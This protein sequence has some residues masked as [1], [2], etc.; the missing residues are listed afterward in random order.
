MKLTTLVLFIVGFVLSGCNGGKNK[1]N[2]ELVQQMMDQESIKAQDW[3]PRRP[4]V[5]MMKVPPEGTVPKGFKPY[6]YKGE[7]IKAGESLVNP[8]AGNFNPGVLELGQKN[9]VIYCG[10]CHGATGDGQ[11]NVASKMTVKPPSLL[12]EPVVSFPDGRI[13]HTITDGK[14]LM[15]SY[16]GKIKK[17]NARWAVVNYIRTLQKSGSK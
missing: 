17:E 2:I 8:L 6:K 9:Y 14:G 5:P 16:A 4:G 3:D 13:F 12:T 11:G 1:T 10:I 7:P 15:S